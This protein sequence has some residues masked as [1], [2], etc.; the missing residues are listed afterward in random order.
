MHAIPAYEHE[1]NC[2]FLGFPMSQNRYAVPA[3]SH[4]FE[5]V[6]PRQIVEI[7]TSVG[8]MT[9]LL[10]IAAKQM[11]AM[12]HTFDINVSITDETRE[13]LLRIGCGNVKEWVLDALSTTGVGII[14]N[15]LRQDGTS[16]LMCDGGNKVNEVLTYAPLIKSGDIIAA[17]D[18]GGSPAWPWEEIKREDVA[19]VLS[20]HGIDDFM[21][22]VFT[23]TGWMVCRKS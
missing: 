3:W 8:G 5:V 21:P 11:N 6:Q 12:L 1:P 20:K 18:Y 10:A 9:C 23:D 15:I 2:R 7:G 13:T 14:R 4:L 22:E 19:E 16:V 17:H